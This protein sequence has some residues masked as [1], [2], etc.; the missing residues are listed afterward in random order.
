MGNLFSNVVDLQADEG[1]EK[2]G[3]EL[4]FGNARYITVARS[5]GGNRKYR[6]ALAE[7]YKPHKAALD[8]GTLDEE[9]ASK[10]LRE[11]FAKAVVLDW[12]GWLD[13]NQEEIPYTWDSCM[14]L[15]KEVPEIFRIVQD[16]AEKFSNFVKQEVED[17]GN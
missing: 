5:G 8:R 16:E 12:R 15:F 4:A 7:A 2:D 3:I 1:L 9:T 10:M 11:V 6:A 14:E 13:K 17:S